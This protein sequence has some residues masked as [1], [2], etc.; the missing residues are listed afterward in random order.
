MGMFIGEHGEAIIYGIIGIIMVTTIGIICSKYWC[1]VTPHYSSMISNT[2]RKTVEGFKGKYPVI[3]VDDIIYVKWK[4][5]S[6]N[7]LD[8]MKA[9]DCEGND[10]SEKVR[11]YGEVNLLERGIY[12]IRYV[13]TAANEL[14]CIK[15]INVIV[16]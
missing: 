1:D 15:Y 11:V 8:Y 5:S 14:S 13:V 2:N 12:K 4:D 9:K 3:E 16:E 6:F 10:I 7:A